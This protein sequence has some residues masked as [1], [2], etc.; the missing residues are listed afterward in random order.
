VRPDR[1]LP[2]RLSHLVLG[3]F[4]VVAADRFDGSGDGVAVHELDPDR[5]A[6]S[7]ELAEGECEVEPACGA[8][9]SG[10]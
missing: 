7:G 10:S 6:S 4:E 8:C 9:W 3:Q 5:L 2:P 1:C